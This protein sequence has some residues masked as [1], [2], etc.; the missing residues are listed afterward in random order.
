LSTIKFAYDTS[1]NRT[2]S[3][4][5]HQIVDD[6]KPRP[7]THLI[8]I[9]NNYKVYEV[10]SAFASHVHK[11]H[12][13]ISDEI[14]QNNANYKLRVDIRKKYK[15]FNV[16]DYMMVRI[17]PKRFPP[18]TVKKLHARN[19]R[20]FKVLNKLNNNTYVIDLSKDFGITYTFNVKDLVDYKG[21]DFNPS[22]SLVDKPFPEPFS[23]SA[24]LL[25]L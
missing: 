11:P 19:A 13:E 9:V 23:E 18:E 17:C 6:F 21:L 5:P 12:K 8:L 7:P 22:N 15:T 16:G 24:S 4:S 2:I 10:V 14:E 25:L 3:K 20:R 1:I